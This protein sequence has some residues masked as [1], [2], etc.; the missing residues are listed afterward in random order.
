MPCIDIS[1]YRNILYER[2]LKKTAKAYIQNTIAKI[3]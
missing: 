2:L 3:N 1:S